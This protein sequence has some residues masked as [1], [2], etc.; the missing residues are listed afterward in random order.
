MLST[1]R[2]PHPGGC[3]AV[4]LSAD[5]KRG[6]MSD[7]SASIPSTKIMSSIPASHVLKSAP[8]QATTPSLD[9]G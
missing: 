8:D 7:S 1:V 2:S 4:A 5:L 9:T 6:R 3:I